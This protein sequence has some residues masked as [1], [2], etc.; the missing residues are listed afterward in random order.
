[1]GVSAKH[2]NV[3]TYIEFWSCGVTPFRQQVRIAVYMCGAHGTMILH[4]T[5]KYNLC[6]LPLAYGRGAH[7]QST[8]I[9]GVS[10]GGVQV[11]VAA[12][13]V[14]VVTR[15]LGFADVRWR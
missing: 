2:A 12:M 11:L 14:G 6:V 15:L 8:N 7:L 13:Y 1:M 4:R 5:C 9:A 3:L 10:G